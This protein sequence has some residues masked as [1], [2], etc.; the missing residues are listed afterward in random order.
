VRTIHH[1]V[2]IE[3]NP[4]PIWSAL[5]KAQQMAAWWSTKLTAPIAAIGAIVE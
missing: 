4:A 2:D 5:T 1:V 3:A